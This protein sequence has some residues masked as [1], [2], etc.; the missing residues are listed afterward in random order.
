MTDYSSLDTLVKTCCAMLSLP[1]PGDTAGSTDP[2][3]VLMRTVANLASL[4]LL[5]AYE[6]SDLT[7]RASITVT[8]SL[9]PDPGQAT[10]LA[11]PARRLPPLHRPDPVERAMRFPAVGPVSPQG[12]QTYM[13]FPISANFT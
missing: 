10:E 8:T 9:P 3:I 5:N 1:L 12:W 11:R 4:E 13:V 2:N 6:W 7:K